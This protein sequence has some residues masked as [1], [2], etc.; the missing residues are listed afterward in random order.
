MF[1]PDD[2]NE[3]RADVSRLARSEK[4]NCTIVVTISCIG[5]NP[6]VETRTGAQRD[7]PENANDKRKSDSA[8]HRMNRRR[9]FSSQRL[10]ETALISHHYE[11][12]I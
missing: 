11:D 3:V 10:G 9:S 5:V 8:R 4:S 12:A 2:D 7:Y 6:L 1:G